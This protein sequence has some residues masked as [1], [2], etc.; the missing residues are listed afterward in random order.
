MNNTINKKDENF[1]Q[2]IKNLSNKGEE[3]KKV[4]AIELAQIQTK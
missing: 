4:I 2:S 3:I 1:I